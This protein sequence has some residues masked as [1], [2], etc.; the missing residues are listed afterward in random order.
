MSGP[1]PTIG[2]TVATNTG[3]SGRSV[4][5]GSFTSG[6][7]EPAAPLVLLVART[8]LVLFELWLTSDSHVGRCIL[9]VG[10]PGLLYL[11]P[12]RPLLSLRTSCMQ[13]RLVKRRDELGR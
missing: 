12:R 9:W 10:K 4:G 3:S 8:W 2:R 6:I 11:L 7:Y 13:V 5:D 1:L